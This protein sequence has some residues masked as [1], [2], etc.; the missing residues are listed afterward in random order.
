MNSAVI[1]RYARPEMLALW[2]DDARYAAWL[3]VELAACAAMESVPD[4][5]IP[6]GT[7]ARLRAAAQAQPP[8]DAARILEIEAQSQ[9]DVIAFLTH[10]EE[11]L[12][13]TA[14]FL[15]LGL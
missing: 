2:S 11:R 5:P 8:L 15:H 1:A 9:H 3:E 7:A 14:R 13:P 10:L 4:S 6:A 12:G